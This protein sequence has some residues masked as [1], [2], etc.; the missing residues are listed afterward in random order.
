MN[1]KE[2]YFFSE[3]LIE[4]YHH[5]KRDLPWRKT[6]DPYI[7]WISEVILQQTRVNQGKEYFLRFIERF[8]TVDDLANTQEDEVLKYWQGLGYYSRARNLY[9]AAQQIARDFEGK[10]PSD[11]KQ[12]LSLKGVGEYT[13][14]AIASFSG[15]YPHATV[16][17]NVFRFLSR[18]LAI[19]EP[20][21]TGKGKKF[22]T[23]LAEQL[24]DK[25]QAGIFN[26]A[27]M[28]FGALQCTP[29]SPDCVNCPF[30]DKCMAFLT[31]KVPEYPVKQNKVSVQTR[32]FHYFHIKY[33]DFTYLSKRTAK[34][35]WQN[36]YEFPM[37]ETSHPLEFE[38]LQKEEKFQNLFPDVAQVK[39]RLKLSG[40]KHV[41][42]HRIL[43][44][45][46]YEVELKE[47]IP[48]LSRL[49][50]IPSGEMDKYAIHRLMQIYWEKQ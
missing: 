42:T 14:S 26:Q 47:E 13:A 25:K 38:D 10:M 50:K 17:G 22:F 21:D 19:D 2:N 40:Q 33:G 44:V 16:D 29:A 12:L 18:F 39:F 32:Y 49:L 23:E 37:I 43:M 1:T 30:G 8:P 7:I 4:W 3:I 20:I 36:L 45:N 27:M 28:E 34:D 48:S 5:N 15:N 9:A 24:M 35:I 41:L 31:N 11:Y 46:F 6:S